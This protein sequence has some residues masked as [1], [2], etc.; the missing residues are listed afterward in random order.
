M[1]NL[2]LR[3][4]E[5][6]VAVAQ[7]GNF[8]RAAQAL[9]ISQPALTVQIRQ[10]ENSVGARLID[11]NTR[12]VKLTSIGQQ[13]S[14]VVRRLLREIDTV[15]EHA[16][17]MAAGRLGTVSVA[18]L[19]SV[20]S[21]VLPRMIAAFR[22][23]NPGIAV[24]MKDVVAQKVLAMVK[25]EEVDFGIGGFT[26]ADPAIKVTPLF[27]DRMKVVFPPR[28]PLARKRT[29]KLMDLVDLPL[30]LMDP[31][32]SVRMLADRA[33]ESI[34][35]FPTPAY[36]ATYMSSAVGMVKAGLGVAFL[37]SAALELSELGGLSARVVNHPGLTRDIVAVQKAG[38]QPSPAAAAFLDVL[39]DGCK[40][41]L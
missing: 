1:N 10:L 23:K 22:E 3:H 32:S 17:E 36:E 14:P 38:R 12:S 4:L 26:G 37:P 16:H 5:A 7:A 15:I 25:N 21:M 11:R 27:K 8:T 33:F 39:V 20:C 6:F 24:V 2:N 41:P 28:H 19:P 34:G 9:H 18:A 35:Y 31:Q 29:V 13:L 40:S 30:I